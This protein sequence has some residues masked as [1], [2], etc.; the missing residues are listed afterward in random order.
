[1]TFSVFAISCGLLG[2]EIA[3]MRVLLYASWHHF[4]FVVIS[5]VL[6]G[7]GASGTALSLL[8]RWALARSD[9][10]MFASA[11]ATAVAIPASI[12][13]VEHIPVDARF[14][15]VLLARQVFMWVIF[16]AILFIPFFFGASAIGL[17]LM[18]AG[19]RLPTVYAAN[20]VGSALGAFG[21]TALMH[22]LPPAWLAASM[23]A[24]ALIAT[25]PF[26]LKRHPARIGVVAG[27]VLATGVWL[28]LDRP[29]IRVDPFKYQSY[30][31]RL[32]TDGR[33]SLVARRLG[34]R[35]VVDA[36][37]GDVFHELPFLSVGAAPPP[38]FA[39]VMDGHWVGSVLNVG[40]LE[41]AGE[42][43]E[44][45]LMSVPYAL[46]APQPR[47]LLLG[48]T[49]GT[50]TWL[51]EHHDARAIDVV[52]PNAQLASLLGGPLYERSGRVVDLAST[53]LGEPRHYVQHAD[54]RY[55]VIQLAN[56]ESWAVGSGG[57]AGLSQ[58][59]L[60]TVEPSR[61]I[62]CSR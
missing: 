45:T 44:Q 3:L 31:D 10:V 4:A 60:T 36:Y 18:T 14:V 24:V 51:A 35:A 57:V 62:R 41:D 9:T 61:T 46:A 1:M 52:Q 13:L 49:G 33:A 19:S 26:F 38:M 30:V 5:V 20:L 12:Q 16:W 50:N 11:L 32:R 34:S 56:L 55:D 40:T 6:L 15:P 42:V 39:L 29:D 59:D 21:A 27:C 17:A 54:V 37:E 48:E 58:D 8:R 2:F 28:W 53:S 22:I 23:G 7:F 47:V 25:A 43:V